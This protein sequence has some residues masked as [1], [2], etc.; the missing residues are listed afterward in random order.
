MTD[1]CN[2]IDESII[3]T[4]PC[5]GIKFFGLCEQSIKG[6]QVHPVTVNDR[7]Q[8]SLNDR[9][10]GIA[11]YR[12]LSSGDS[13]PA[14]Y[15]WGNKQNNVFKSRLRNVIAFKVNKLSEEFVFDFV[16]AMPETIELTGYKLIDVQNNTNIVVDQKGIYMQEFGDGDYEKHILTWNIYAIEYD[17]EFIKC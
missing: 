8:V 12:L 6:K 4:L 17:V 10:D 13:Q 3:E 1:I 7:V 14:E 9:Y 11:Y 16:N 5:P 15:Q 2:A